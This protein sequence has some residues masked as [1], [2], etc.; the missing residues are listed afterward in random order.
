MNTVPL[1]LANR[2]V[3]HKHHLT[4]HSRGKDIVA[5]TS[6]IVGLHATSAATPYL[7]LFARVHNFSHGHLY[8]ELYSKRTLTKI[9]CFRRTI[10]I[11]PKQMIPIAFAA[12]YGMVQPTSEQYSRR[13]G[14]SQEDYRRTSKCILRLLAGREMTTSELRQ[15]LNTNLNVSAIVNLMCDQGLLIRGAPRGD[16]R[17][18]LHTYS[19]FDEHFPDTS[20]DPTHE[21]EARK[22]VIELYIAAFGPVTENDIAWWTGFR[23]RQ[24]RDILAGLRDSTTQIEIPTLPGSLVMLTTDYERLASFPTGSEPAVAL[25][26]F[27]DSYIMGYKDRER[28]LKPENRAYVFDRTGNAASVITVDGR[29]AGVW[30]FIE[31]SLLLFMLDEHSP[32]VHDSVVQRAAQLGEFISQKKVRVEVRREMTPL[33]QRRVGAFMSPL[34]E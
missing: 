22:A 7:S 23:K 3:L 2:L 16:W 28:Y 15:E 29:I 9:R 34:K 8:G 11:L 1:N 24:V 10:Y 17:S 5:V 6:D 20:L 33:S 12:T 26:P 13:L 21:T 27:L 19:R 4:H 25:L 30:D 14:V 31:P 18:N 32:A